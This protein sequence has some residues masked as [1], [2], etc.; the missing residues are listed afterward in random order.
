MKWDEGVSPGLSRF[1][2]GLSDQERNELAA[3]LREPQT[4]LAENIED[5]V[6]ILTSLET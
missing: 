1:L 4:Y 5:F 2:A 6:A 3:V